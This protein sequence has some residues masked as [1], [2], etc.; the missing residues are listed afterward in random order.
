MKNFTLSITLLALL[1][2]MHSSNSFAKSKTKIERI[3][4]YK[5]VTSK[6]KAEARGLVTPNAFSAVFELKHS[7]IEEQVK[8]NKNF[9][10]VITKL[11]QQQLTYSLENKTSFQEINGKK[12]LIVIQGIT[13][14]SSNPEEIS[15][16]GTTLKKHGFSLIRINSAI[17]QYTK[18]KF[19]K[20]LA[21]Q[22]HNKAHRK[23]KIMAQKLDGK[24]KVGGVSY[25][26]KTKNNKSDTKTFKTDKKANI[27]N[28]IENLSKEKF[29]IIVNASMNV[30]ILPKNPSH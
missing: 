17:T 20:E 5:H 18:T 14:T 19:S 6:I 16:V 9:Q 24:L 12:K 21:K 1:S 13:I 10:S 23:A 27:K 15:E 8:F 3:G 28:A 22:A 4:L 11:K 2:V 25:N 29:E 30:V 26:I 7:N